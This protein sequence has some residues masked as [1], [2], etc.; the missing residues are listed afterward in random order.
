MKRYILIALL[1]VFSSHIFAQLKFANEI[2][3]KKF[4][5]TKTLVVTNNDPFS[6]FDSTMKVYMKKFWT[7]T[8]YEF[9]SPDDF[10]SK[11]SNAGNSFIMVSEAELNEDGVP[12]KYDILNFTLGGSSNINNMP[13]LGSVPLCITDQDEAL[14]IYKLGGILQYMQNHIKYM[15]DHYSEVPSFVDKTKKYNMAEM[16]LWLVNEDLPSDLNT[17]EKIKKVYPFTVKIVT[18]GEI[19]KAI[20]N[21]TSNVVYLHKV[22]PD[23]DAAGCKCT[24][25]FVCAK[26]GDVVYYDTHKVDA[27]N[28]NALQEKDL[29]KLSKLD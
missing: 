26:D 11:M 24:K 6:T 5:T 10:E 21:K 2:Q 28:Q 16:E 7:I 19:K 17:V 20:E 3:I 12:C 9:I 23:A 15:R 29:K 4:F 18:T 22:G 1:V 8:P 14:Y 13:D 25:F 27:S